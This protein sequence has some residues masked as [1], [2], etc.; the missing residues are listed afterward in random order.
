MII[1]HGEN[2]LAS[3][4]KLTFLIGSFKGEVV[5][6]NGLT[7]TLTELKQALESATLFKEKRLVVVEDFFSRRPGKDKEV[8]VFYLREEGWPNL[9]FW[10]SKAVDGRTLAV[11]KKAKI[12]KYDLPV[13]IFR[14]LDSFMPQNKIANL[15]F[16]HLY[17]KEGSPELAFYLLCRLLKDLIMAA[18]L[19]SQGL[20][21]LPDWKKQKL[22]RQAQSFGLPKLLEIYQQLLVIE[23]RQK[24]GQASLPL[25]SQLDLLIAG[26]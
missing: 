17:L 25:A 18:D 6:L 22:L 3:R 5:R 14:F 16:F 10:E 12:E 9:I 13:L 7:L 2:Q 4:K 15:H 20:G 21:G 26:L 24:T 1:L 23:Y 19:G 8:I 11:F